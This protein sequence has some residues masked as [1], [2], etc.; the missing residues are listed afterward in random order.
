MNAFPV[1][2]LEGCATGDCKR[3]AMLFGKC[4]DFKDFGNILFGFVSHAIGINPMFRNLGANVNNVR[5]GQG[6]EGFQQTEKYAV[7]ANLLS[8]FL[9]GKTPSEADI[10]K[11]V[12]RQEE[13]LGEA[14][15]DSFLGKPNYKK[16]LTCGKKVPVNAKG[17]RLSGQTWQ[18]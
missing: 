9:D 2:E 12:K 17:V 10:E 14:M 4:M 15:V 11:F 3:T 6:I 18:K 13:V 5:K 8:S 1:I 16:C 7:W